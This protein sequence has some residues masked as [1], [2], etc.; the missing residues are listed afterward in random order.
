MDLRLG[1]RAT[2][3]SPDERTITLSDGET[4]GYESCLLATGGRVRTLDVPGHDLE[5]IVYLRTMRDATEL[6][7]LLAHKPRI[8]VVGAGFIGAEVAASART[9]GCEVTIVEIFDVPLIRVLGP[10]LGRTYAEIHRDHGVDLRLGEE[11]A[12]FEGTDHVESVVGTGGNTYPAELVV[13]GVGIVP[14]V[15]LGMDAG[16]RCDNGIVVDE[17]CRTSAPGVFAAGD[18]A[19][20]P[21]AFSGGRIRVEHFQNAQNQGAAAARNMLGR[22]EPFSEV[23]WFWSDQY[24]VNLQMLGHPSPEADRILRGKVEE[25]DFTALY[26]RGDKVVAAVAMNRG[27]DIAVARRLIERGI[28]VDAPRLADENLDLRELLK[29]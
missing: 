10:D 8:V 6:A 12:R 27:R 3:L 1:V 15:E 9:V 28:S 29:S 5:G 18:V 7:G 19:N 11:V 2:S 14:N 23:P 26:L 16:L 21:D 13:V 20:R 17:H 25:R 4:I 24:D 22:S